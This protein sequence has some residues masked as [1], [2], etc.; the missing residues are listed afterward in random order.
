L[1]VRWLVG[2]RK[3]RGLLVRWGSRRVPFWVLD[4]EEE[5]RG[6]KRGTIIQRS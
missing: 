3:K 5:A 4:L 2:G 6:S 1:L